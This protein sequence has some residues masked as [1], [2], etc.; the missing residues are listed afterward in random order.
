MIH[1]ETEHIYIYISYIHVI[2]PYL[3]FH[4]VRLQGLSLVPRAAKPRWWQ[5]VICIR[6]AIRVADVSTM[7]QCLSGP[8]T[9]VLWVPDVPG[10]GVSFD[11]E[12]MWQVS[13]P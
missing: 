10:E 12:R 1:M 4:C 9:K 7:A 8:L 11:L 6:R 5:E 3:S 13:A 2:I